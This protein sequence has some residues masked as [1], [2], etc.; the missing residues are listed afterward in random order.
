MYADP[1]F[2]TYS[3]IVR[4]RGKKYSTRLENL[5]ETLNWIEQTAD[6]QACD[7]VICLGDFFDKCDLHSEELTALQEISWIN[8]PH[9]FI[10]GN[11]EMGRGN[12]EFSSAHLFNLCPNTVTVDRPTCISDCE[13]DTNLVL[14]PY[15]LEVNRQPLENYLN[16]YKDATNIIV[17]SHNDIAGIQMGQYQS[18]DGFAVDEIEKSCSLFING[19]LHNGTNIGRK[20][21]NLGNITG[22]NFS[23]DAYNYTH[24]CMIL[25]TGLHDIKFIENPHA[26]NFYKLDLTKCEDIKEVERVVLTL[27]GNSVVTAKVGTEMGQQV[28]DLLDKASN[29]LEYRVVL[30][31]TMT[32][33][34]VT[35]EC[36]DLGINHIDRFITYIKSNIG[37]DDIILEELSYVAGNT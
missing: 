2:S 22:Q 24:Q 16:S 13:N 34:G 1:H 29:I 37:I 7:M 15:I 30:N 18:K 36:K 9:Y 3:S 5:I 19:H 14:L 23:E 27:K 35:E 20:I 17:L 8:R 10:A 21:I 25:D 11:H 12:L 28:R 6:E 4:S 32:T 31:V 33:A 26:M